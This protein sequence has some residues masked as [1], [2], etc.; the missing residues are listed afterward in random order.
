MWGGGSVSFRLPFSLSIFDIPSVLRL[1]R[2]M[3]MYSCSSSSSSYSCSCSK[4]LAL[5]EARRSLDTADLC[6]PPCGADIRELTTRFARNERNKFSLCAP[7]IGT[8][9]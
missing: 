2:N 4:D 7:G 8:S 1:N 5:A 6:A 3:Y 9:A